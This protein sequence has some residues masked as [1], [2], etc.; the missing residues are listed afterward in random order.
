MN[1]S[2]TLPTTP[3]EHPAMD[4]AFLR[5]EGIRLLERLGGRLWTD[6]N[7][8]DPG[9]TILE[10]LCYAITDL[11]Y[12]ANYDVKDLL[13]GGD[14]DPYR[15]LY[16]PA[17][18]LTTNPVTLNDLR[19][20]IID[21]A[22]V[23]NAWIEPVEKSD[24]ALYYDPSQGSLYLEGLTPQPPHR[25]RVPLRG[26]YRVLIETDES[27][28]LNPDTLPEV[29]RRLHACRSLAEDFTT[30]V[31]LPRL[32]GQGVIVHA[33]IEISAI[34]D[35]ARLLAKIYHALANFIS[36]RIR[37]YT[38]AE[39]L[40]KG[41]D[42]DEIFDGPALQHGFIDNADLEQFQ[43]KT[44]LR[45]SDLLQE[46]MNIPGVTSVS[47]IRISLGDKTEDWYLKLNP[48]HAHYLDIGTSLFDAKGPTISL[49]RT[50]IPVR[51]EPTQVQPIIHELQKTS[52]DEPLPEAQRDVLLAAGQD[53]KIGQYHSIQH[54]FPATYGIGAMGLPE[55]ASPERKAQSKQLKAYLM[56]FDQLLANY[57]AQLGNAKDLF[58]FY[59]EQSRT[60]FSQAIED[61]SLG[62]D[63]IIVSDRA[64]HAAHMRDWAEAPASSAGDPDSPA[65]RKN[66]FLNHLLARF[67]EQ[68]TDYSLL[69]FKRASQ[70]ELIRDKNAF[71]QDYP[72]IGA[73]RGTGFNYTLPAWNSN[74]ISGLEKRI[75]LKLGIS[76]YTKQDLAELKADAEGGFHTIEHIL[77]RPSPADLP[78]PADDE[79][80]LAQTAS[81]ASW[82]PAFMAKPTS[83]DP[84][85][86][87]LSFVFPNWVERFKKPGSPN[88]ISDFIIKTLRE[89]TPAHIRIY[90]HWLGKKEMLAFESAQKEW[91]QTVIAGRLWD[92]TNIKAD[93]T[94]LKLRDARD[95]M[96]QTLGIGLPYPL[97]DVK[98]IFTEIVTYEK[99]T[100][101]QILGGQAGVRY[102]LCDEDGN[103]IV[104]NEKGFQVLPQA[105]QAYDQIFLQTPI[106]LKDITFT[107]L[108]VLEEGKTRL[109]TYLNQPV[110]IK[111][112]IDAKLP[113]AFAPTATQSASEARI[114]TNYGDK[115]TVTVSRSQEGISYKLVTGPKEKPATLSK[116]E[117]GNKGDIALV[118]IAGFMEDTPIYVLA[119]RTD[120]SDVKGPLDANLTV[121]VRP[122]PALTITVEKSIVDY[123]SAS[124]LTLVAP[125]SS[126]EYRLYKRDVVPAEYLPKATTGSLV[127]RT[128]EG[129]D[130]AVRTP[131]KVT[132]WNNPSGFTALNLFKNSDGNL[133]VSTGNLLEDALFIVQAIKIENREQLQLD[134][135]LVILARPNPAPAVSVAKAEVASGATGLVRVS[136][137][138][139]GVAYQLRLDA[140]N[141]PVNPP[142]Y[143]Q[144][145]RGI[146]TVRLEVD[147]VVEDQGKAV[148]LLPTESITAATTFNILAIKTLT[149]VSTQLNDKAT[150][151]VS[152]T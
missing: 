42:I 147:F 12:R 78:R 130:V 11:G 34:E 125:Q 122:N 75:S 103:A 111:A 95:R 26:L 102:Q 14:E 52:S 5:A 100:T 19:K 36:P 126:V 22:G 56:F 142:G 33:K 77:L 60:Y 74:N 138:Q 16:S 129:R 114:T 48:E 115:V 29:N 76:S 46:I 119:Y 143:H 121:L 71:L 54:Q 133:S 106:I 140:G 69:Q 145:D 144:T 8:H 38:L 104:E 127:V 109:E 146:E 43:R 17:K 39:M 73:A 61:A 72:E 9:I 131:D 32:P 35:P 150:I 101:I 112:G 118:S 1:P 58:S 87:Q 21:V 136:G 117:K 64:A 24:P 86:H 134:Q 10:Q 92:S 99:S 70:G 137:T 79:E 90:I 41:K 4:Y 152:A 97:R 40:D 55:S 13:A 65:G 98:L 50:G 7:A 81:N 93:I 151:G 113:V 96:I 30:P 132:D 124:R 20:L 84:Y 82:Q 135:T 47:S 148:L 18:V 62:L 107:I 44:G 94:H 85:S 51:L 49:T 63:E 123:K 25:A 23:K 57:F 15:S 141:T 37:F 53:R 149:G 110:P 139:K 68:F 67:A 6:F 28:G 80:Q 105:G 3:L 83:Q 120:K 2:L 27:R 88:S 31:V 66:R 116:P 128:D 89:E 91:M 108:A 45:T 59:G